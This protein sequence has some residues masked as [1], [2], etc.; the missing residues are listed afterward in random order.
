L[1]AGFSRRIGLTAHLDGLDQPLVA[2]LDNPMGKLVCQAAV[3]SA[4]GL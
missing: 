1:V 3:R 4:A 2:R